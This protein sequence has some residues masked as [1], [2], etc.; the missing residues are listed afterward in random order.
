MVT[1]RYLCS[2]ERLVSA[3]MLSVLAV[4]PVNAWAFEANVPVRDFAHKLPTDDVVVIDRDI[5]YSG[6]DT[7]WYWAQTGATGRFSIIGIDQSVKLLIPAPKLPGFPQ[8]RRME[9]SS[10]DVVHEIT[11][12]PGTV[13]HQRYHMRAYISKDMTWIEMSDRDHALAPVRDTVFFVGMP[14]DIFTY[15]SGRD[16]K[17]FCNLE[18][19]K[20]HVQDLYADRFD[21][22]YRTYVEQSNRAKYASIRAIFGK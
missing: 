22:N 4:M 6:G 7:E 18:Q 21:P 3:V 20:K 14:D 10:L 2:S 12:R 11:P 8:D 9:F 13:P 19:L 1:K 16:G 17:G 5:D 15:A